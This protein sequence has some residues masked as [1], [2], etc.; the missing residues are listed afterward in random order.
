MCIRDRK[1]AVIGP[2]KGVSQEKPGLDTDLKIPKRERQSSSKF[3][4]ADDASVAHNNSTS[5]NARK[6]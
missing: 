4:M 5:R 1:K 2:K 3:C 6:K